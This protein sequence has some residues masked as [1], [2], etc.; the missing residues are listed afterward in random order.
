MKNIIKWCFIILGGIIVLFAVLLLIVPEF[1]D[2]QK[3]KP[4]VEKKISTAIGRSFV[5]GADLK[6]SLFPWAGVAFSDLY[7]GN[8]PGFKEK[9]FVTI[10]SFDVRIKLIPLL[11]KNLQVKRFVVQGVR[12]VLEKS[13]DG[14]KNWEGP[15]KSFRKEARTPENKKTEADRDS[16]SVPELTAGLPFKS[17]SVGEFTVND[18][19]VL[20]IDHTTGISKEISDANIHLQDISYDKPVQIALK[21]RVDNYPV[22]I[23]GKLGPLG[24][25]PGAE[26][27]PLAFVVKALEKLEVKVAGEV[28]N[29]AAQPAFDLLLEVAP[30]SPQKLINALGQKFTV[31]TSDPAVLTRFWFK[32]RVS[33][34]SKAFSVSDGSIGLDDTRVF[35]T[36]DIKEFE[37]PNM[38]FDVRLDKINLD[39]YLP[40]PKAEK[41]PREGKQPTVKTSSPKK[42]KKAI[43]YKPLRRLKL[44]SHIRIEELTARKVALQDLSAT[45]RAEN[46]VFKFDP[47]TLKLYDGSIAAAG[48]LDFRQDTP[49]NSAKLHAEGVR[50]KPFLKDLLNKEI[51]EGRCQT[52]IELRVSGYTAQKIKQ[53][54][55]GKGKIS[56]SDGAVIGVDVRGMTQNIKASFGRAESVAMGRK[57]EFSRLDSVFTLNRG[58]FNTPRTEIVATGFRA[59]LKGA[60]NLRI[61]TLNF[62]LEPTYI[63]H[64]K[65]ADNK[66]G[67][68]MITVPVLITG[69]FEAPEFRPDFEG[70]LRQGVEKAL[71]DEDRINKL[72][73]KKTD[74][75][76]R[77]QILKDTLKDLLGG[78]LSE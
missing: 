43:N 63:S 78:F 64:H 76:E 34:D 36:A 12:I 69:S 37:R 60:A 32:A 65:K 45:V 77:K 1:V 17:V 74:K 49:E 67:P 70:A 18:A 22:D 26:S 25:R 75:K 47:L 52:D 73:E 8:P 66:K 35:F 11:F 10:K 50:V 19:S 58:V 68:K 27:I 51:L 28:S 4:V 13:K 31:K 61:E 71:S 29:P 44:D 15:G 41:E 62:R 9:E 33:G 21:A 40:P 23:K 38:V 20:W 59:I 72:L 6:L 14:S 42:N 16:S 2:L 39:R 5:I 53:T 30:F 46:G 54:L 56:L 7:I 24:K 55:N 48:T 57:T 3:Y